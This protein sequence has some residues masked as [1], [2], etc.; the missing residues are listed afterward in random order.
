[1]AFIAQ[2]ALRHFG[3]NLISWSCKKQPIVATSSTGRNSCTCMY[4]WRNYMYSLYTV[5]TS[6]PAIFSFSPVFQVQTNHI[7]V[8]YHFIR[9]LLNSKSTVFVCTNN[10]NADIFTIGLASSRFHYLFDTKWWCRLTSTVFQGMLDDKSRPQLSSI[11]ILILLIDI[12]NS[13]YS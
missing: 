2:Q 1:M 13:S 10:Q 7:E 6:H 9:E 12:L 8:Y 4:N 3:A 11:Q 5:W